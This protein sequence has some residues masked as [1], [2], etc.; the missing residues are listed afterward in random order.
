MKKDIVEDIRDKKERLAMNEYYERLQD[1]TTIDN[2]LDP[3]ASHSPSK[4]RTPRSRRPARRCRPPT[5]HARAEVTPMALLGV[6]SLGQIVFLPGYLLLRTLRV[7]TGVLG[8]CILSFA[9]SLVINHVLVA[10]LV[11]LGVYRPAVVY[12]VF[13]AELVL[14]LAVDRRR[15][16]MGLAEALAACRQR[17]RAFLR[18]LD[19]NVGIP[20]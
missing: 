12:A 5:R 15:L 10:G 3:A 14:L 19:R 7:G 13:A 11:V 18:D 2:F 6:L 8:T 20:A 1:S 16:R 9:L 17:M 4:A